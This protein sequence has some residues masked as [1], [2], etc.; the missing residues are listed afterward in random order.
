[1][2]PEELKR[3]WLLQNQKVCLC[4]GIPRKRFIEEIS[5]G[6]AS[7]EEVNLRT[8]SGTGDCKGERCGPV[9][10]QLIAAYRRVEPEKTKERP[11]APPSQ[12]WKGQRK[13]K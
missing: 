11:Q 3:H 13:L 8:G 2:D 4:K 7:L 10:K 6:A 9:I 5:R 12:T 1:M